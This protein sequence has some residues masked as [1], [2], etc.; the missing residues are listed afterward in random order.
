MY[1]V[2]DVAGLYGG[3]CCQAHAACVSSLCGGFPFLACVVTIV[4]LCCWCMVAATGNSM[5]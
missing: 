4:A 1:V 3:L 5:C 2:A